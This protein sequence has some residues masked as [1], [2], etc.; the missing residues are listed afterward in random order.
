MAT[1]NTVDAIRITAFEGDRD[2][3][4]YTD[5]F[6][7]LCERNTAWEYAYSIQLHH[8][9]RFEGFAVELYVIPEERYHIVDILESL[10]YENIEVSPAKVNIL[11]EE[12]YGNGNIEGEITVQTFQGHVLY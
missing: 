2:K 6:Y 4:P 1:I 11:E 9:G 5:A 12:E 7:Y 10:G 3:M 8:K